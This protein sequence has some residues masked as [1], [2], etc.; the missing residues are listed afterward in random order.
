M[1]WWFDE[2]LSDE[3]VL[4]CAKETLKM[5]KTTMKKQY[6]DKNTSR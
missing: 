3:E 4:A 6:A 5:T 2:E 1:R